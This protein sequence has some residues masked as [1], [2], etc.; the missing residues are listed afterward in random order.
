M[1]LCRVLI[2]LKMDSMILLKGSLTMHL[3]HDE[4]DIGHDYARDAEIRM[5]ETAR[6]TTKHFGML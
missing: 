1:Q 6:D 4:R 3:K 5:S 2:F